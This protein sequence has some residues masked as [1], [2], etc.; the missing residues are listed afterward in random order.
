MKISKP[1]DT[2]GIFEDVTE[3][4]IKTKEEEEC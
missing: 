4:A 1:K 3:E 2:S